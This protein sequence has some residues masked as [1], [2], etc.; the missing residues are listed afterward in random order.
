[1]W[2]CKTRN[3]WGEY[4]YFLELHNDDDDDDD[5]ADDIHQ[6]STCQVSFQNKKKRPSYILSEEDKRSKSLDHWGN[7]VDYHVNIII[8]ETESDQLKTLNDKAL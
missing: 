7:I 4:G 6:K 8:L 5:D 2:G 3:L 1:M